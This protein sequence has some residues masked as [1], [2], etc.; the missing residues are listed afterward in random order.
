MVSCIE[1]GKSSIILGRSIEF[2]WVERGAS[3]QLPFLQAWPK[4]LLSMFWAACGGRV[5]FKADL[6]SFM[7]PRPPRAP[8]GTSA[9]PRGLQMVR[10]PEPLARMVLQISQRTHTALKGRNSWFSSDCLARRKQESLSHMSDILLGSLL[11]RE[12][13]TLPQNGAENLQMPLRYLTQ[14]AWPWSFW[15]LMARGTPGSLQKMASLRQG[16]TLHWGFVPRSA[17]LAEQ[18]Q[19]GP[20]SA[21]PRAK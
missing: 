6:L 20:H 8:W 11:S 16:H 2:I 18:G 4:S 12:R 21:T 15:G 3:K 13:R 14:L 7:K 9:G 5:R 17:D 1:G 10:F 19:R